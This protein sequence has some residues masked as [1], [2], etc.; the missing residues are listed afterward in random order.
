MTSETL[1]NRLTLNV[2]GIKKFE[3]ERHMFQA[4]DHLMVDRNSLIHHQ[5]QGLPFDMSPQLESLVRR[6]TLTIT[7]ICTWIDLSGVEKC[8][9]VMFQIF[10]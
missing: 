6:Q 4:V 10:E 7:V 8:D 1:D 3:K 2:F 9:E 5:A